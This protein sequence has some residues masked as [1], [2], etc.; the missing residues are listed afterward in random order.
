MFG[1]ALPILF[2]IAALTFIN[3][4]LCERLG[5]AYWYTKPPEYGDDL[6]NLAIKYMFWAPILFLAFG[7]WTVGN[8]Q[9][10]NNAVYPLTNPNMPIQTGHTG[11]PWTNNGPSM[12]FFTM[13]MLY[14]MVICCGPCIKAL[15][16]KFHL[17][18][19]EEEEEVD[20]ALG[21]FFECIPELQRKDWLAT[22]VSNANRLGIKT[23]G[24][25][26]FEQMRTIQGKR[27]VLKNTPS[28]EIL[29]NPTYQTMFQYV[30]ICQR[31][32]PREITTSEFVTLCLSYPFRRMMDEEKKDV[33]PTPTGSNFAY[34][35]DGL[36]PKI[37]DP[38]RRDKKVV[39]VV[40]HSAEVAEE[41]VAINDEGD[42]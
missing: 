32:D 3:V 23:M 20:E 24:Q 25:G 21:N 8:K 42:F 37:A 2:P 1:M 39:M 41:G 17:N 11:I 36:L 30:S 7:Y 14:C 29:M 9:M 6:N 33:L 18:Q 38:R 12:A 35:N 15:L 34:L 13:F 4:Y 5:I 40:D 31:D 28:Y 19:Q 10:F 16:T 27:R 22:E 26:V